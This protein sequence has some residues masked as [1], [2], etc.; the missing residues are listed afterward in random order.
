MK[1]T[2]KLAL[3]LSLASAAVAAVPVILP[4][5]ASADMGAPYAYTFELVITNPNGAQC[6]DGNG[7]TVKTLA[8]GAKFK[9]MQ[10]YGDTVSSN[11]IESYYVIDEQCSVSPQ[12]ISMANK[13]FDLSTIEKETSPLKQY[14]INDEAYLYKGPGEQFG[15]VDDNYHLPKGIVVS[16]DYYDGYWM[17]TS[18]EGH[19]GWINHFNIFQK[20]PNTADIAT[21]EWNSNI[22]TTRN[23][24]ELKD[25]PYED[26]KVVAT[27]ETTPLTEL[28]V[29]YVFN[30]SKYESQVYISYG[31]KAGWYHKNSLSYDIAFSVNNN[32]SYAMVA[33]EGEATVSEFVDSGA[34]IATI[35]A[36]VEVRKIYT[37]NTASTNPNFYFEDET[38]RSY[39][40]WRDEAGRHTGWVDN[41]V[42][43]DSISTGTKEQYAEIDRPI[44]DAVNGKEIGE[45]IAAGS[46]YYADYYYRVSDDEV[47]Y[48]ISFKND[49][50]TGW[51]KGAPKAEI[52]ELEKQKG[53]AIEDAITNPI[54]DIP[55]YDY[56]E[57]H[58]NSTMTMIWLLVCAGLL[59]AAVTALIIIRARRSGEKTAGDK[60]GDNKPSEDKPGEDKSDKELAD[61]PADE[62]TKEEPKAEEPKIEE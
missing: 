8:N 58:D 21:S 42:L 11:K 25:T 54:P 40:E 41:I 17:Y 47:W 13:N 55:T 32:Y 7:K 22:I 4:R 62:P 51:I 12:D 26:G 52:E 27:I 43:A 1:K 48:H 34:T 60:D 24:V 31:D 3:G 46:R 30:L 29:L 57:A 20:H 38:E 33:K 19:T 23:K 44:L 45:T 2:N 6:K 16:A 36:S 15:K 28:P 9:A 39:V 35:P 49:T 37:S 50:I 53:K 59:A 5:R 18:Y 56:A 10:D 61:K 14:V